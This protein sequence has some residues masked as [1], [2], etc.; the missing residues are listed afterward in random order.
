[1]G[2]K[3]PTQEENIA[4]TVELAYFILL[5]VITLYEFCNEMNEGILQG[6]TTWFLIRICACLQFY[7]QRTGE[8]WPNVLGSDEPFI[9]FKEFAPCSLFFPPTHSQSWPWLEL[10]KYLHKQ[11]SRL[12]IIVLLNEISNTVFLRHFPPATN[13]RLMVYWRVGS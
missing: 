3:T 2:E 12:V 1:M 10:I 13:T 7:D 4:W 5:C 8:K 9:F 11:C 6:H